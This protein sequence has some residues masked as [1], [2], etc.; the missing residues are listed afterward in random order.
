VIVVRQL[1]GMLFQK[2]YKSKIRGGV[3]TFAGVL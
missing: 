2:L 3:F 1:Y